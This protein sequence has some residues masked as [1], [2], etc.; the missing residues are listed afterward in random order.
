MIMKVVCVG[1]GDIC[2]RGSNAAIVINAE[3][4]CFIFNIEA[5]SKT[6]PVSIE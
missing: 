4:K 5:T 3:A 2:N 6:L 1:V